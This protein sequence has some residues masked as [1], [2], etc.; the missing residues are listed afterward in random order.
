[1]R[2][3][4]PNVLMIAVLALLVAALPLFALSSCDFCGALNAADAVRCAVCGKAPSKPTEASA[5]RPSPTPP[6]KTP[7]AEAPPPVVPKALPQ[8]TP[9]PAPSVKASVAAPPTPTPTPTPTPEPT[10]TP[11]PEPTPTP[12]PEPTPTPTPEPTLEPSPEPRPGPA[13]TGPKEGVD[14]PAEDAGPKGST[15]IIDS[16]PQGATVRIRGRVVGE[17]PLRRSM[18][19]GF[20]RIS[21]T[22]PGF[23]VARLRVKLR[24]GQTERQKVELEEDSSPADTIAIEEDAPAKVDHSGH[25]LDPVPTSIPSAP[26]EFGTPPAPPRAGQ[27]TLSIEL[28]HY[29]EQTLASTFSVEIDG[30]PAG[31]GHVIKSELSARMVH[32]LRY[33]RSLAAGKHTVRLSLLGVPTIPNGGALQEASREFDVVVGSGRNTTLYHT[34]P[35][36]IEEFAQSHACCDRGHKK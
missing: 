11:T 6:R 27:G 10:P 34:W 9:T 5:A 26:I 15:L 30:N 2:I 8:D 32:V 3:A 23:D 12:T 1:M 25:K 36:G 13:E 29:G 4:R 33:Q 7:S 17:T 22:K 19:A 20:Y 16:V 35:G 21:L 24:K 28:V 18:S 31:K 14:E